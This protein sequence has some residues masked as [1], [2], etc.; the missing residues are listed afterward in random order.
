MSPASPLSG[1]LGSGPDRRESA[2]DVAVYIVASLAVYAL[3]EGLRHAGS[4]PLPG[5]LDGA[6]SLVAGFF[7]VLALTRRRGQ[8]LSALGL[9]RPRRWITIPAWA[10]VILVVHVLSQILVAPVL[11]RLLGVPEPDLTRY[12]A[13]RGNLTLFLITA[14]GAMVTGGFMEEVIY[15]GFMIDRLARV[16]G[17]SRRALWGAALLCGLPFGLIHF[18]WGFGGIVT[19]AVMGSILGLMYMITRRN[20]WPLVA[21][22]ATLD[23]LLMLQM[24][25]GHLD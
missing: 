20:L 3:E 18:E 13:L 24:Y 8:R 6:P 23:L 21:A 5:L 10:L 12:D 7:V 1:P 22:H 14:L 17:G 4:F 11:G 25:L 16:L 15:R 9:Y 19:T 2:L